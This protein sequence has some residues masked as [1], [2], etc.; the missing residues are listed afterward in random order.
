MFSFLVSQK[1]RLLLLHSPTV[2]G[3][4]RPQLN[5]LDWQISGERESHTE[6]HTESFY[7]PGIDV[8][9]ITFT[10]IPKVRLQ[11]LRK[12]LGDVV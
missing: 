9:H 12:R 11:L 1:P 10:H 8:V 5:P 7:E 4:W 3:P 6:D 2:H